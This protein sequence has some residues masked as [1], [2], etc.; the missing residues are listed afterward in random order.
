MRREI[1][2]E[3]IADAASG[4]IRGFARARLRLICHEIDGISG[5]TSNRAGSK[6]AANSSRMNRSTKIHPNSPGMNTSKID[7]LQ[8]PWN[9]DL[10]KKGGGGGGTFAPLVASR[11]DSSRRNA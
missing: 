10:Q 8:P 9:E 2:H 11:E 4:A 1:E 6:I 7:V 5:P 3:G